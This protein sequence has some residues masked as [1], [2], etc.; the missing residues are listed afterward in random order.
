MLL[1][2]RLYNKASVIKREQCWQKKKKKTHRSMEQNIET[3]NKPMNIWSINL[4]QRRQ[5]YTTRERQ[6]L[7]KLGLEKPENYI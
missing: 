7:Q 3:R 2:F 1:D 5:E 6:S 4:D